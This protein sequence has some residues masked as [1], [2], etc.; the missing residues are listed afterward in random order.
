MKLTNR[1]L[2]IGREAVA[3]RYNSERVKLEYRSG[4]H[5]DI[6]NV[7]DATLAAQMAMNEILPVLQIAEIALDSNNTAILRVNA[8]MI[9]SAKEGMKA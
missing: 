1:A 4:Q 8:S 3:A 2:R 7:R 9:K 6:P 5:D